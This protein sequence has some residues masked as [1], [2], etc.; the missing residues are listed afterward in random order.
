MAERVPES[1]Q[2]RVADDTR[3][4]S[5]LDHW[6]E[7]A[8][9]WSAGERRTLGTQFHLLAGWSRRTSSCSRNLSVPRWIECRSHLGS[10][11]Y[12]F[13]CQGDRARV[14]RSGCVLFTPCVLIA[15]TQSF[16]GIHIALGPVTGGP[17]G[18]S[19]RSIIS[20]SRLVRPWVKL[21]IF[22][23]EVAVTG[24][25]GLLIPTHPESPATCR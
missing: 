12:I 22:S 3:G 14:L 21:N 13:A 10:R 24:K 16:I 1:S 7:R 23:S 11:S 17:L 9:R 15:V 2:T 4:E 20:L 5:Q 19:P 18:R 8:L 6:S 25:D